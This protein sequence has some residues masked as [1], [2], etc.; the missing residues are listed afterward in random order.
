MKVYA[1]D[2][3]LIHDMRTYAQHD[4]SCE[5]SSTLYMPCTCGF[6]AVLD[7]YD[8]MGAGFDVDVRP[9]VIQW[10][11]DSEEQCEGHDYD[12][13]TC[14]VMAD[15]LLRAF[16]MQPRLTERPDGTFSFEADHFGRLVRS[17]GGDP[18]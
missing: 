9:E 5:Y 16:T 12:P 11:H 4:Q 6:D 8:R 1:A 2:A 3:T 17:A 15:H 18:A 14:E 13:P 7:R 10:F